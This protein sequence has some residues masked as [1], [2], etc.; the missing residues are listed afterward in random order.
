MGLE[1]EEHEVCYCDVCGDRVDADE[2]YG[3]CCLCGKYVCSSCSEDDSY[4]S[5]VP[6]CLC[7]VCA[8]TYS[9]CMKVIDKKTGKVV[10]HTAWD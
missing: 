1:V 5:D 8:K 9:F 10:K 6:I 7:S 2:W 3:R 4:R